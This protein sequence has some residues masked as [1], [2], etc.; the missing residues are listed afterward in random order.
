VKLV[1]LLVSVGLPMLVMM[2]SPGC[3]SAPK[4]LETA[5]DLHCFVT[6]VHPSGARGTTGKTFAESHADRIVSRYIVTI[7]DGTLVFR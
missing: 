6:E 1:K 3:V 4:P 7:D 5:A 2:L